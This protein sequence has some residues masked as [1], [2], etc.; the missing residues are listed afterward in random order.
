VLGIGAAI[1]VAL[2]RYTPQGRWVSSAVMRRAVLMLL[3]LALAVGLA[4]CGGEEDQ[5]ALPETVVGTLPE[6]TE[7]TDT[8]GEAPEVEGDAAAGEGVFAS[9]GCGSC[10]TLEA[11]GSEGS[12]GPN[13]DEASPDFET[14][15]TTIQN[16]RGAMP[17]FEDQLSEQQ[18]ADVAQYVVESTS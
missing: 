18:I 2:A 5:Q 16:G 17:A 3:V 12:I 1:A 7:P 10:H 11:A 15:F 13:L 9:S 6:Q 4:G 14:A 8:G